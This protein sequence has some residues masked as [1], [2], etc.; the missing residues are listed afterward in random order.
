MIE[1]LLMLVLVR[2][3]Q[4]TL[5]SP[6]LPSTP[7][8]PPP[9]AASTSIAPTVEIVVPISS[10]FRLAIILNSLSRFSVTL[11]SLPLLLIITEVLLLTGADLFIKHV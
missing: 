6:H 1:W 4:I 11:F 3:V 9:T 10:S 2:I 7:S 8:A 5:C